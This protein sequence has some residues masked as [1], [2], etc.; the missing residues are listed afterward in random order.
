YNLVVDLYEV[1]KKQSGARIIRI[2]GDVVQLSKDLEISAL[3]SDCVILIVARRVEIKL[4]CQIIINN[5]KEI[6]SFKLVIYTME[7]PIGLSVCMKSTGINKLFKINNQYIGGSLSLHK[8]DFSNIKNFDTK[9]F[10]KESFNK[11]LQFSLQI[12]CTLFYDEPEVARSIFTWIDKITKH[13]QSKE[14]KELYHHGL[15]MFE[16]SKLLIERRKT[17]YQR[18]FVPLLDKKKFYERIEKFMR[19]AESYERSYTEVLSNKHINK[20]E[21]ERLE[22]L[23]VNCNNMTKSHEDFERDENGC[24]QSAINV[25]EEA[26]NI[27]KKRKDEVKFKRI[28]FEREI[29]LWKD[30]MKSQTNKELII[31]IIEL[32][33]CVGKTVIQPIGII[34]LIETVNKVSDSINTTA[35]NIKKVTEMANNIILADGFILAEITR[36]VDEIKKLEKESECIGDKINSSKTNMMTESEKIESLDIDS[37]TKILET[38][39]QK[40]VLI[41]AEWK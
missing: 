24:Y 18:S 34:D 20:I 36:K 5:E 26:K 39:D 21:K 19:T 41:N 9:I 22:S 35:N 32:S 10:Q 6:N 29:E 25:M 14:V 27:L 4:G 28:N 2:Y 17:K 30:K 7:M 15:T 31:A 33:L 13:S 16:Q 11:V 12:A 8:G 23:L 38:N 37:L 3:E 1:L 40:G